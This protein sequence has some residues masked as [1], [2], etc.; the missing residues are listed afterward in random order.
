[1]ESTR[2]VITTEI[3]PTNSTPYNFVIC[4]KTHVSFIL[5]SFLLQNI[6]IRKISNFSRGL[7]VLSVTCIFN[8]FH[9]RVS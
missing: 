3:S 5:E 6:S 2:K 1:M 7:T 8:D 9:D 4:T